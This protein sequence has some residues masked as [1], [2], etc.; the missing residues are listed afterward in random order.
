MKQNKFLDLIEK[1]KS[2][3]NKYAKDGSYFDLRVGFIFPFGTQ[4]KLVFISNKKNANFK[5]TIMRFFLFSDRPHAT[6]EFSGFLRQEA[7]S[8]EKFEESLKHVINHPAFKPSVSNLMN[9]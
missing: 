6:L 7:K 1:F 2:S 8:V 9:I 4:W 5:K 3:L